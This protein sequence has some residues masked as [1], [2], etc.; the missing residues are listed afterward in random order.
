MTASNLEPCAII[1]VTSPRGQVGL[2]AGSD[3]GNE[4]PRRDV[5]HESLKQTGIVASEFGLE[6]DGGRRQSNLHNNKPQGLV[7]NTGSSDSWQA[8]NLDKLGRQ[9][10]RF[11][12]LGFW[13]QLA[14]LTVPLLLLVYVLVFSGPTSPKRM[15]IDLGNYLSYGSLV[16]ML[17]TTFW[18]FRY[19]RVGKQLSGPDRRPPRSS[20]EHTLWIGL[21]ASI[22]GIL[23]SMGLLFGAAGRM[24]FIL[25][26]NPQTGIMVAPPPGSMPTESL[27]AIDAVSLTSLLIIL[28]A[29]LLVLGLS[30]W[31]LFRTSRVSA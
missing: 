31:L 15:G 26:A 8:A 13:I 12:W 29:E 22:I 3:S 2:P 21:W 18:F 6:N 1:A 28:A 14:L 5:I 20:V 11:G 23:F 4:R 24:L 27:S 16:V 9:F 30:V 19:T 17:F 25:L 7:M 10:F